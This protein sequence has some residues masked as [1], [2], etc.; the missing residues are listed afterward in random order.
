D[1]D[2]ADGVATAEIVAPISIVHDANAVLD[3]GT[4]VTDVAGTVTVNA[5]G[6]ATATG[7]K[8]LTGST[9][10]ADSFTVSG[11]AGRSFSI[12]TGNGTVTSGTDTMSFT[13]SPSAATGTLNATSGDANFT[14]GGV[15]TVAADQAAGAY[16]GSYTATATYN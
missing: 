14:V 5:A 16:T 6:A 7:P 8:L 3:F 13:T 10:S 1:T 9:N 4:M 15:L 12:S 11:D 2:S